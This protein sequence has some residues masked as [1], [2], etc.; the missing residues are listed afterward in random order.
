ML[1]ECEQR[2]G[3]AIPYLRFRKVIP[4]AT[5]KL[6]RR[7]DWRFGRQGVVHYLKV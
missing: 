3:S 2:R 4:V 6:V 1:L 7:L 5:F